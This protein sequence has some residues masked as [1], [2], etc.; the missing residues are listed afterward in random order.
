M[1]R[2]H[3]SIK[4]SVLLVAFFLA[5]GGMMHAQ[6]LDIDEIQV[7]APYEPTISDAFKI[8]IN[9]SIE[10]TVR[11]QLD[12][13]YTISPKKALTSFQVAPIV[14]AR[15][16]GEPLPGLYRGHVKGGYGSYQTPYFE[17]FYNTLR[18]N[19]HAL[20]VHVRHVSSGKE[21][22]DH[23]HS[24]FSRNR[25]SIHGTRFFRNSSLEAGVLYD[26]HVVHYYG[27]PYGR[28]IPGKQSDPF[29]IFA[30]ESSDIR[31]RHEFV[32]SHLGFGNSRSNTEGFQYH[33]D[34]GHHWYRDRYRGNE[35][36]FSFGGTIGGEIGP[37]P[38]G[39][40]DKQHIRIDMQADYFYQDNPLNVFNSGIYSLSPVLESTIGRLQFHIGVNMAVEDDNGSYQLMTYPLAGLHVNVFDER[41]MAYVDW[42]GGLE[43][44]SWRLLSEHNPFVMPSPASAFTNVRSKIGGGLQG[45]ISN[46]VSY[47]LS[48]TNS[49]IDNHPFFVRV[50]AHDAALIGSPAISWQYPFMVIYDDISLLHFNAEVLARIGE[51]FSLRLRGDVF[52]YTTGTQQEAWHK[53]AYL[54]SLNSRYSFRGKLIFTADL[55]GH[56]KTYGGIFNSPLPLM[57][58]SHKL[59]DFVVDANLGVEYRYTELLSIFLNFTN[60]LD[61][62]YEK[63]LYYPRQGFGFLGGISATF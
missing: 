53:P 48:L 7:I 31:Q 34:L 10:D 33:V 55:Y 5:P 28:F 49:N 51:P 22:E 58:S 45:S 50:L 43:K 15:M 9:P 19:Q 4:Y 24:L 21:I 35:H 13:D 25:A 56:G 42:S 32:S 39:I 20:G 29:P 40:A 47:G 57:T 14:P 3:S 44:Q 12:F 16:R 6:Q 54:L 37:D 63:W 36:Q 18:S 46:R 27:F 61:E 11:V 60:V 38:F 62:T 17:A 26:R 1:M 52:D 23:P 8:N 59:H 30:P 2:I 41:L